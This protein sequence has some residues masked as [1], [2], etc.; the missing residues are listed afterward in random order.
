MSHRIDSAVV[1][2]FTAGT[3]TVHTETCPK[4]DRVETAYSRIEAERLLREH[5]DC[6]HHE[7]NRCGSSEECG[8]EARAELEGIGDA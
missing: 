6:D 8:C 1:D 4:C 7:C 2:Q 3:A 5:V